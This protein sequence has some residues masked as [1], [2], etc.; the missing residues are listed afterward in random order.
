[1]TDGKKTPPPSE[2]DGGKHGALATQPCV[3]PPKCSYLD[4]P[5]MVE[6]SRANFDRIRKRFDLTEPKPIKHKF[7]DD[8]TAE[9][10]FEYRVLIDDR[11][12]TLIMP[13]NCPKGKSLPTAKQLAAALATVPRPQLDKIPRVVAS[14]YPNPDDSKWAESFNKPNATSA[15]KGGTS[16]V[17]FFA[18]DTP[19][20][21]EFT[22]STMIHEGGHSY[23]K[24]LWRDY[25]DKDGAW[26][27]AIYRDGRVPSK[28]AEESF[29]EDFSE[30]LVMY[31][32]S[33]GSECEEVA[34]KLYPNRYGILDDLF[35][36]QTQ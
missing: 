19:W 1:V 13:K 34:K 36:A 17:T 20:S 5:Y 29:E 22:D 2:G 31:C 21:Q 33:K 3:I 23:S 24:N 18:G 15:G 28:Y 11:R 6:S 26:T 9:D 30:S 27:I 32:L 35:G 25:P 14:P 4:T 7:R 12:K 10:A 16:G 8:V